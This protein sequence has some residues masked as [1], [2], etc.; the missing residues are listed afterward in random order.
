MIDAVGSLP[1][2]AAAATVFVIGH[3]L[4]TVLLAIALWG[5]IPRW[6]AVLLAIS[7]PLHLVFAV[8]VPNGPLDTLAWLLTAFGFAVAGAVLARG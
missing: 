4:G 1:T 2:V 5:A 6:V 3:I 8:I 7:Q